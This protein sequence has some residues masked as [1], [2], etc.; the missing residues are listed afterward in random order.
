MSYVYS[1]TKPSVAFGGGGAVMVLKPC[2]TDAAYKRHLKANEKPCEP[3]T[4]AHNYAVREWDRATNKR[5]ARF[6]APCGTPGAYQRHQRNGEKIDAACRKAH[7]KKERIRRAKIRKETGMSKQETRLYRIVVESWPTDDGKPFEAQQKAFWDAVELA[8]F[9]PCEANQLPKGFETYPPVEDHCH[10]GYDNEPRFVP[11]KFARRQWFRP[12]PA[13]E[14]LEKMRAWGIK[15][16]L[17]QS[18]P[19]AWEKV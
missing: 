3:C 11:P 18:K 14:Q 4:I 9:D 17:E 6:L 7:A 10:D 12:H 5:P 8:Y 1:G 16:H 2:G 15:A 13:I 19:I